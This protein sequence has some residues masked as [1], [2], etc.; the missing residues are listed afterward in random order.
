[1]W[2]KIKNPKSGHM[3]NIHSQLGQQI[4]T[5]YLYHVE[6]FKKQYG[7]TRKIKKIA[8]TLIHHMVSEIYTRLS[9]KDLK[10]LHIQMRLAGHSRPDM[11]IFN[12]IIDPEIQR[13]YPHDKN[14]YVKFIMRH[15]DNNDFYRDWKRDAFTVKALALLRRKL[16]ASR[17]KREG[18][19]NRQKRYKKRRLENLKYLKKNK[20]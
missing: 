9:G 2:N 12:T 14:K 1:M 3:V 20:T 4:L 19:I 11:Y 7:G 8:M 10:E 18:H 17:V 13:K 16:I 15:G 6:Q 5:G